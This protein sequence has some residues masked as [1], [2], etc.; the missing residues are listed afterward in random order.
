MVNILLASYNGASYLSQQIDSILNQTTKDWVLTISDDMST[1]QTKNIIENYQKA[2]PEKIRILQNNSASGSAKENFY[3]LLLSCNDNY[4]MFCDQDDIWKQDKIEKSLKTIKQAETLYGNDFPLLIH[5]DLSVVDKDLRCISHSMAEY[6]KISPLRNS[7]K[8]LLVQ[9]TVTGCTV[10]INK[11]LKNL[12]SVKPEHYTMHDWWLALIATVFGKIIY[13]D[14][15]LVLY[16]QH[17]NNSV[18]A[19]NAKNYVFIINKFK[20]RETIKNNY[21]EMFDTAKSF[22]NVFNDKLKPE[23]FLTLRGFIDI[24]NNSRFKKIYLI[25][26]GG[27]YKNTLIRNIGQFFSI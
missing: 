11:A 18:G 1:D 25:I 22:I 10:I 15:P 23:D 3:R 26:R 9:N 8:N 6:Q 7:L 19:K 27:Y 2:Y 24:Q 16:R 5:S 21:R 20:D 4:I 17:E 12:A 13:I 14:E